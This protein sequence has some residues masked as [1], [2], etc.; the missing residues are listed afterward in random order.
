M[1]WVDG[2]RAQLHQVEQGSE[3]AADQFVLRS[4]PLV[5]NTLDADRR[6]PMCWRALLIECLAAYAVR[7]PLHD[8]RSVGDRWQEHARHARIEAHHVAL[9]VLRQRKEDLVEARYFELSRRQFEGA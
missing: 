6:R 7:E 9:R 4:V 8:E 3:I 5:R 1:P 2:N